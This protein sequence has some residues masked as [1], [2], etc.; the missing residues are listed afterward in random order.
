MDTT[1]QEKIAAFFAPFQKQL[2]KKGEILIRA[3]EDPSGVF[4]LTKGAIKQYFLTKNG[5][6]LVVNVFKPG[7]FSP[8][9]WAINNTP[10]AFYFEA[11]TPCEIYKAPRQKIVDFLKENPD[12][13][14]D[15][16]SRVYRGTDG[17]LMRMAYL[18]SG[19]ASERLITE[20]LIQ[21]KRFGTKGEQGETI[22]VIS[23][24]DLADRAGLT[25]ETISRE[26][27]KLREKQLAIFSKGQIII[28]NV[29]SLEEALL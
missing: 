13:L 10:N 27:K 12:V 24:K 28:P 21:A 9:S 20:L 16:L 19:D 8:M 5:E 7:S 1:I 22:I 18:M 26:L 15:L 2:Y 25:R 6:E 17:L 11:M 3:D 29:V 4:Y 14:F 23:E